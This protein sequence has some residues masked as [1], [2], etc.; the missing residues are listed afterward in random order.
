MLKDVCFIFIGICNGKKITIEH[1][2]VFS[3][4]LVVSKLVGGIEIGVPGHAGKY[5]ISK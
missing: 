3:K 4:P 5:L 2:I 1:R